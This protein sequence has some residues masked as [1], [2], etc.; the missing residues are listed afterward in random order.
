MKA[1]RGALVAFAVSLL[2]LCGCS[3]TAQV[4]VVADAKGAGTVT[5]TVTLDKAATAS[6]GNVAAELQ[7]SDLA[8]AGWTV[9][10]PATKANGSTVVSATKPFTT[11][12][13]A[14]SIVEEIA[15]SGPAGTR[16]FQLVIV[17][18]RTFWRT[19]TTLSGDV[20][21]RCGLSCFGDPGLER[22]IGSVTGINPRVA[23]ADPG[24]IFH[25]GMAV[26][27]PGKLKSTNAATDTVEPTGSS[28][29]WTP[30][31]GA[32]VPLLAVTTTVDNAHIEEVTA[33]VAG[34]SFVLLSLIVWWVIHRWRKRR[35][36]SRVHAIKS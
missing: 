26:V 35:R 7:T 30:T 13:Q 25:F 5:V 22:A 3:A 24:R 15:G 10:G 23:G 6:I 17:R 11:L 28:L 33:A 16:P 2:L 36:R 18:R 12:A 29:Q 21:L 9:T 19:T 32:R 4:T 27:L 34:G 14:S 1:W 8:A 31:L 20:D